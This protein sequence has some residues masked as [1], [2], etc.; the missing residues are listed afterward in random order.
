MSR[1]IWL[2]QECYRKVTTTVRSTLEMAESF[3]RNVGFTPGVIPLPT[4]V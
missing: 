1:K 4:A 3:D 2:I